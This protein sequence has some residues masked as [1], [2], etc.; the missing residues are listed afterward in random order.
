MAVVHFTLSVLC[1][2]FWTFV[3]GNDIFSEEYKVEVGRGEKICRKILRQRKYFF[4]RNHMYDV[5]HWKNFNFVETVY[6]IGCFLD[7]EDNLVA[8]ILLKH[9]EKK[10]HMSLL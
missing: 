8:R 5:L 3:F 9:E 7:N 6:Y 4:S 10:R 1:V 2:C